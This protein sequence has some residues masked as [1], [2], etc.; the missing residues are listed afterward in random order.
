MIMCKVNTPSLGAEQSLPDV[1][2]IR[3]WQSIPGPAQL[4]ISREA[5]VRIRP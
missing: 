2:L 5:K 4:I 1:F 3:L